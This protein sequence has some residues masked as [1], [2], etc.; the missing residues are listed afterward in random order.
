MDGSEQ[1]QT[2]V[3]NNSILLIPI[4]EQ[5]LHELIIYIKSALFIISKTII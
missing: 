2:L 3:L 5:Q 1:L 4:I